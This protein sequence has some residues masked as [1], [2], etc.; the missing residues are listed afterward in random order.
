MGTWPDDFPFSIQA[1]SVMSWPAAAR[2]RTSCATMTTVNASSAISAER[3]SAVPGA[4]TPSLSGRM[5]CTSC[6]RPPAKPGA[7]DAGVSF[8]L[9][10]CVDT[11]PLFCGHVFQGRY[12]TDLVED[13]SYL[14]T[15]TRCL[16]LNPVRA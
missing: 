7:R 8:G 16:H 2:D 3:R 10:E 6:S 1:R 12:R 14:W 15:V 4:S 13:E 5:I 9:R 11:T